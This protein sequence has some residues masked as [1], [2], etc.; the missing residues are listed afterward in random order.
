[1]PTLAEAVY[2]DYNA[3]APTSPAVMQ[4]MMDALECAGNPSSVHGAGRAARAL[5]EEAREAVAALVRSSP[6][7]V[8]FTSGATEAN[9]LAVTGAV[10]SGA[11]RQVFCSAIEHPSVL[12]NVPENARLPVTP[13]GTVDLDQLEATLTSHD[14]PLLI[15]V[16]AANNETGVI[17]PI[18]QIASLVHEN[19][20]VLLCDMVQVPGKLNPSDFVPHADLI[21]LSAHKFGGPKG[22]G[23]LINTS[24]VQLQAL[25]GGG[26]Q[27]RKLRS[28]TENVSGIAGF[29]AAAKA[30]IETPLDGAVAVL[31]DKLESALLQAR[32]EAVIFGQD[33]A[34]L[35]N[36]TCVALPGTSS[37]QQLIKLDLAGF[38]VSA[39]SACSSGKIAA[40]H[41]LLAMGVEPELAKA[42]L[43]I[44][45]GPDTPWSDLERFVEAWSKV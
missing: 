16:M 31:R 38:A 42:S 32:E 34:R 44:S 33:V 3:T 1:M 25:F 37:E 11:V 8:T 22:I 9:A 24:G 29:G 10:G 40:S 2:L 7:N 28:G 13:D 30:A 5:L 14:T 17:Q 18:A 39:G 45:I 43:R 21:T 26:G 20:G 19:D 12:D 35:P 36:T 6:A 4:A 15:C 41:V 23:A 27:E